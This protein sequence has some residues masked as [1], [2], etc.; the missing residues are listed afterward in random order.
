MIKEMIIN[1]TIFILYFL[2]QN[3]TDVEIVSIVNKY[4]NGT[5]YINL[6]VLEN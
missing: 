4:D 5:G 6:K 3:P 2:G 1:L